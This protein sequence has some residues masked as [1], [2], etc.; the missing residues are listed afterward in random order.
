MT[1]TFPSVTASRDAFVKDFSVLTNA[2]VG[3]IAVRTREP[4]RALNILREMA[5]SRPGYAYRA[6]TMT[7]GW[8]NHDPAQPD[9]AGIPD[10]MVDPLQAVRALEPRLDDRGNPVPNQT[11][12]PDKGYYAMMWPHFAM[13]DNRLPPMYQVIAKYARDLPETAMRLVLVVPY[14][15]RVV[16]ELEDCVTILDL[17]LPTSPE[18]RE[19]FEDTLDTLEERYKPTYDAEGIERI[20]NS[21][22]GMTGTE[23]E[24]AVSRSLV[25]NRAKLPD[26]PLDDL[27]HSIMALKTEVVKRSEVLEVMPSGTM[28]EVG[29]LENLKSWTR[30]RRHCFTEE[31]SEFGV[32]QPKGCALIGPPGTGKS[33][34]AKAIA[35]EL[36]LP[37]IKFD[38]SRVFSSLVGSSEGKVR[39]ALKQIDAMAPCVAF[40]D[41]LDKAFDMNS[42]GGDSGVGKRVL[43]AILTH[44]QE[45]DKPVFWVMTA[46]RTD[47]LP[48][49]MLRKGRLDEVFSVSVPNDEERLEVLKIHLRKRGWEDEDVEGISTAV[50]KS[51]GYVPAEIEAAVKEAITVHFSAWVEAGKPDDVDPLTGQLIADQ[52]AEMK[53]LSEAFKEQFEKMQAW[54]ESNARPASAH[55]VQV[56]KRTRAKPT[57]TGG[58]KRKVNTADLD[59]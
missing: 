16:S 44:M 9:A 11:G 54:A 48:P 37:L 32:D 14:E 26:I 56:R 53:P 12:F 19:V 38:V 20:I 4:Y 24:T 15:F 58:R 33:L 8:V 49:E 50:L 28:S 23:F 39:A 5:F 40:L 46:N 45:S 52:L 6:W 55:V 59:G 41:E 10:N 35:H 31:A 22:L 42:G 2:G 1:D 51:K 47:G 30:M 25:D 18:L 7:E 43:G 34:S 3:V 13:N 27:V 17:D 36:G 21:G 29:G 57:S